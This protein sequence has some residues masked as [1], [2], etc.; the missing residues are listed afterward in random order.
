MLRKDFIEG[1]MSLFDLPQFQKPKKQERCFDCDTC[2]YDVKR[3]C[4][5]NTKDDYCILGDKWKPKENICKY[6][7]HSCNKEELWKIAATFDEL[8][9]PQVC[10]RACNIRLCG[11]R[12]NGSEEPKVQQAEC[13]KANECEAYGFGCGG[14]VEP[15]RFGGPYKWSAVEVDIRGIC[16]DG[17]CPKCGISLDDL[18]PECPDCHTKL[19]WTRWK[20]LNEVK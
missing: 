15:C 19:D 13:T 5:Y 18:I 16:D 12:C 6:S 20:K 4:S 1:Q 17:Y 7:K 14:T 2:F 11:A 8:Q 9:C 3:C 10:C